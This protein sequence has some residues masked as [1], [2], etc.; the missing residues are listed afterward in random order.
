[1]VCMVQVYMGV[2]LASMSVEDVPLF[3]VPLVLSSPNV[4]NEDGSVAAS[5]TATGTGH[6]GVHPLGQGGGLPE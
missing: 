1:M 2:R 4:A 3:S 5:A 6:C